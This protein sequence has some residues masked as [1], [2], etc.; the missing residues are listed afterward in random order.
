MSDNPS[1]TISIR[2]A[3]DIPVD[4]AAETLSKIQP[5]LSQITGQAEDATPVQELGIVDSEA[6]ALKE[7][8]RLEFQKRR[9]EFEQKGVQAFRIYRRIAANFEKPS[10]IYTAI[11][12]QLGWPTGVIPSVISARRK[13]VKQYLRG[14]NQKTALRLAY[15]GWS[16]RAIAARMGFHVRTVS[17]LL[18]DAKTSQQGGKHA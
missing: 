11:G 13:K 2:I 9:A 7:A 1:N 4:I 8:A 16:N 15:E 18:K 17:R 12:N 10:Q 6:E 5:I 3:I 14:R